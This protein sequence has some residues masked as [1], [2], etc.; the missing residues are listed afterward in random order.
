M[1]AAAGA[2]A[3]ATDGDGRCYRRPGGRNRLDE[4]EDIGSVECKIVVG[5]SGGGGSVGGGMRY[6]AVTT[7]VGL[8]AEAVQWLQREGRQLWRLWRHQRR[9]RQ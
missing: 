1:A 2:T 4:S 7:L 8:V 9:W 6:E 3:D 5:G